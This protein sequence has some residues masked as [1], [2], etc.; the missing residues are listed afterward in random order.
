MSMV[1]SWNSSIQPNFSFDV[2]FG[3]HASAIKIYIK[4]IF[5]IRILRFLGNR[6]FHDSV[7]GEGRSLSEVC[8]SRYT[9]A[10]RTVCS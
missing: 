8:Q 10:C 1:K 5:K 7:D 6:F 2:R 4:Y 9:R 3:S